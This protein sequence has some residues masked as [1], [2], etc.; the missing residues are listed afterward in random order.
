MHANKNKVCGVDRRMSLES[1]TLRDSSGDY[2]CKVE[3]C[4]VLDVNKSFSS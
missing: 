1:G 4:R 3:S 2:W